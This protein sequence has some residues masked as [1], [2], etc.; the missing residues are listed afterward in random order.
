MY[1]FINDIIFLTSI[2]SFLWS[3]SFLKN[4]VRNYL[5][6]YHNPL[7]SKSYFR[8]Y[9][10]SVSVSPTVWAV[11]PFLGHVFY[12]LCNNCELFYQRKLTLPSFWILP[13]LR[14]IFCFYTWMN[15]KLKV[16]SFRTYFFGISNTLPD[17]LLV[18]CIPGYN[19]IYLLV[20]FTVLAG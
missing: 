11:S 8:I 6:F 1:D 9:R 10:T 16:I 4:L 15:M 2:S 14:F 7:S 20:S 17:C 19:L 13:R 18:L 3:F 12:L 5:N